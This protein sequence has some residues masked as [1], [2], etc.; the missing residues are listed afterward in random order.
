M[1]V[2]G[3]LALSAVLLGIAPHVNA[4]AMGVVSTSSISLGASPWQPSVDDSAA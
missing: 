1:V 3:S 4:Q 2:L